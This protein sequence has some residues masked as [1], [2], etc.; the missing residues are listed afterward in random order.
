MVGV[1]IGQL[2][3]LQPSPDPDP[4]FGYFVLGIPLAA[5]FICAAIA[6]TVLGAWRFWRQQNAMVRGK[7]H[8]GGWEI[9]VIMIGSLLVSLKSGVRRVPCVAGNCTQQRKRRSLLCR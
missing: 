9:L 1:I 4:V 7:I 6:V 3:R 5:L 8:A 2:F